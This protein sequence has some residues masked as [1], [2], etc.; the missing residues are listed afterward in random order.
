MS[1][2]RDDKKFDSILRRQESIIGRKLLANFNQLSRDIQNAW[3]DSGE[4]GAWA[5][6]ELNDIPLAKILRTS[7]EVSIV[8]GSRFAW[9]Q[10]EEKNLSA[11]KEM[12]ESVLQSMLLWVQEEAEKTAKEMNR[13]TMKI[14][15]KV[16]TEVMEE[17]KSHDELEYK[18]LRD[19]LGSLV[20]RVKDVAKRMNVFNRNRVKVISTSESQKGL[21]NGVQATAE[22]MERQQAVVIYKTWRS[23][24]DSKVRDSHARVNGQKKRIGEM[25]LVGAGRGLHPAATTLPAEE[26]INCRCYLRLSREKVGV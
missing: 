6:V 1:A 22:E 15:R 26:A 19:F 12:Q 21:Q 20:D 5:V 14:F 18:N 9:E 23:Q 3:L 16:V 24:G 11:E 8:Q 4:A 17:G 25:F 13:T 2:E 7:Y 10:L